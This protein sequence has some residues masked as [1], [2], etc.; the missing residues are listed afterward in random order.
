VGVAVVAV[1]VD[2]RRRIEAGFESALEILD[3]GP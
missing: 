3:G 2:P 1:E